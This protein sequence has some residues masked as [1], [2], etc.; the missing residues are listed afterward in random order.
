MRAGTV[1]SGRLV[2][3]IARWRG[4]FLWG[5]GPFLFV[6]ASI[7]RRVWVR[8]CRII[9]VVGSFGKSTTASLVAATLEREISGGNTQPMLAL[10]ILRLKRHS[11]TA[12]FEAGISRKRQMRP[13]A[14]MLRPDVVVVTSI[15]SE[16]QQTLGTLEVIRAEKSRMVEA[17][18]PQG[19]AVLNGDDPNVLWMAS[20]TPARIIRCGTGPGNDVRA[21]E[22]RFHYPPRMDLRVVAGDTET[23]IRSRL[24]GHSAVF[25][26][27]AAWVVAREERVPESEALRRIEETGAISRRMEPIALPNGAWAIVDD[28]KALPETITIALDTLAELPAERK[29][30]VMGWIGGNRQGIVTESI[31]QSCAAGL[32]RTCDRLVLVTADEEKRARLAAAAMEAGL[33]SESITAMGTGLPSVVEYLRRELRPGDAVLFKGRFHERLVRVALALAGEDVRCWIPRCDP[34]GLECRRCPAL[35]SDRL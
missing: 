11:A 32:V 25:P 35:L 15:G 13:L 19:L 16:H 10:K 9:V 29:W 21:T 23:E 27:L 12:V 30:V 33:P 17:L 24:A 4:I 8:K 5:M 1:P 2:R 28:R 31:L 7:Y 20:R 14:I 18:R 26:L 34:R 3:M 6:L 22:M